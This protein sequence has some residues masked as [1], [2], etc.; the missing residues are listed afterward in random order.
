MRNIGSVKAL[1]MMGAFYVG[2][3][4]YNRKDTSKGI[5]QLGIRAHRKKTLYN[6][7]NFYNF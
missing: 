2:E 1:R 4:I 5:F 3:Y 6:C 7:E